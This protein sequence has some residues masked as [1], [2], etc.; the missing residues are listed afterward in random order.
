MKPH[1]FLRC[2]RSGLAGFMANML[3]SLR[4]TITTM[5][6]DLLSV[7]NDSSRRSRASNRRSAGR[8]AGRTTNICPELAATV[9]SYAQEGIIIAD[10]HGRVVAVNEAFTRITGYGQFEV[11]EQSLKALNVIC[12]LAAFYTPMKNAL[13]CH[14][15]WSGEIGGRHKNGT[16]IALR[17]S[18]SRVC[19]GNGEVRHYVALIS[20][21]TQIKKRQQQLEHNAYHDELTQLP[22]RLLLTERMRQA[23]GKSRTHHQKLAIAFIDLDGFKI[24]NDS[25]GHELGDRVLWIVAQR[26]KASIRE[27]DTLARVGG[28]EFVAGLVGL[29]QPRDCQPVLERMLNAASAPIV[30]DGITVQVS[31]SIGVAF[32]PEHGQRIETLINKADQAMYSSKRSGGSRLA[33]SSP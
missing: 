20:D 31:A 13:A 2:R 4:K 27:N 29:Q 8:L 25:Y 9:F 19:A 33:F 14:D 26:I 7:D 32:F 16:E 5:A 17:L 10:A 3:I 23:I 21:I 18:V 6:A 1:P 28:D 12:H 24:V 11:L 22:N 15:N 30:V